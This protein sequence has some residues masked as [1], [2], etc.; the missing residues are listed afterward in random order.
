M[1]IYDVSHVNGDFIEVEADFY[2]REGQDWVFIAGGNEV[3]RIGWLDVISVSKST[4]RPP[5][6][7]TTEHVWI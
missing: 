5:V 3:L 2:E 1:N 7:D 6:P 4:L